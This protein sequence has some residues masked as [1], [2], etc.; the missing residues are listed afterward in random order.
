MPAMSDQNPLKH[1]RYKQNNTKNTSN[2]PNF[3]A[4][5]IWKSLQTIIVASA[6]VATVFTMW[7][8]ANLFSNQL[9]ER[10]MM[11]IQTQDQQDNTLND[12]PTPTPAQRQKIGIIAGHWKYDSGAV[13]Q[14]GLTE[15]EVNLR[16]ATLVRQNLMDAG[17]DVDL[18]SEFDRNL[19][20][21]ES[22]AL[23]SIHNDSCEYINNEATGFK[24]ADDMSSI[25]P[26]KSNRLS[27]C[28]IQR[29]REKTGLPFHYNTITPDMD[30]YHAFNEIHT[31]TPSAIIETGFLN[32]DRQILTTQADLVA[33]GVSDGIL[34]YVRN[35]NIPQFEYQPTP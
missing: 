34:C 27:A 4:H 16:I 1:K 17:F 23:V 24:V 5:S 15:M 26:E 19:Y 13:C 33:Q 29:Y 11:A 32:M 10:M 20:Q 3:P 7:T 6:V 18:L 12:Y 30:N 35:E 21:Y 9:L 25:H 28:L 8:P 22:I 14:D 31:N 2:Q